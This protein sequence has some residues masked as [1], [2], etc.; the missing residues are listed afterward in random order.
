MET[1]R[2]QITFLKTTNFKDTVWFYEDLLALELALDQGICRIYRVAD[3]A[4]I[5]FCESEE[6][7]DTTD[8]ILT[9]VTDDVDECYERLV[10]R[11]VVF[12]RI[13][14]YN[15]TYNIY[16]CWFRD[17]NGYLIEIQRFEDP[18]WKG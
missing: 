10:E 18:A 3:S 7:T 6:N 4:F 15:P 13:P 14:T 9:L 11:G 2:S 16:H 17:P 5:G 8:V 1:Y 12:D